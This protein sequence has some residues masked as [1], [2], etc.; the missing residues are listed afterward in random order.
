M[1]LRM[2]PGPHGGGGHGGPT[3]DPPRG[4]G[5]WR[6]RC[7][8]GSAPYTRRCRRRWP[9]RRRGATCAPGPPRACGSPALR[10]PPR[11]PPHLGD[12][13]PP[14]C[15]HLPAP[16]Q[17][18][19]LL[20]PLHP[21][22]RVTSSAAPQLHR[23]AGRRHGV[24]RPPHDG[25]LL[26]GTTRRGGRVPRSGWDASLTHGSPSAYPG[27]RRGR[28]GSPSRPPRWPPRR[29]RCPSRS[30]APAPPATSLW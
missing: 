3:T 15:H 8:A 2:T 26:L 9:S 20:V 29:R 1:A 28:P 22:R 4:G 25:G 5:R 21:R 13:P 18:P 6:R 30:A 17:V 11:S 7:P 14:P 10:Q 27:R 19:A 23:A 24:A 16:R 12:G